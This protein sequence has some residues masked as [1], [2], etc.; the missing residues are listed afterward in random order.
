MP[1]SLVAYGI[2]LLLNRG[3]AFLSVPLLTNS[4]LPPEFG[5]YALLQSM[6]IFVTLASL[7][8]MDESVLRYSNP[9]SAH[10]KSVLSTALIA[11]ISLSLL[12][13]LLLSLFL[14]SIGG[15][16]RLS[17]KGCLLIGTWFLGDAVGIIL[18]TYFRAIRKPVRV[19]FLLVSQGI[20]L[21]A[22]Q[23]FFVISQDGG[24]MGALKSHAITS[25]FTLLFF[26]P[27][28]LQEGIGRPSWH[29]Y[30][31]LLAFGIPTFWICTL[32][33]LTGYFD[34]FLVNHYLGAAATG[35]YSAAYKVGAGT[36][37]LLTAFKMGW[38]PKFYQVSR[39]EKNF[40]I[41]DQ[42]S[43]R[44][45]E[46][47]LLIIGTAALSIVLFIHEIATIPIFH[48]KL[49]GEAYWSSLIF[50]API[51]VAF[52]LDAAITILD[53][54]MYYE[55]RLSYAI[56]AAG[57]AC[58]T[59]LFLNIVLLPRMG[60]MGAALATSA[61]YGVAFTLIAWFNYRIF[62]STA[63]SKTNL[64]ILFYFI[65][66]IMIASHPI[67]LPWRLLFFMIH[68]SYAI[69]L[70]LKAWKAIRSLQ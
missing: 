1:V 35:L 53:S 27:L 43:R 46:G 52:V 16:E 48:G 15:F 31:K 11:V 67:P 62:H 29:Q 30:R 49:I 10:R 25:L 50:V 54:S 21:I 19:S 13:T 8:G 5:F 65:I 28:F 69:H 20:L 14:P 37:L 57:A 26:L 22:L 45:L 23:Y 61:A 58:T 59:N 24:V 32:Y 42:Y 68:T 17:G 3:L 7:H 18:I 60:L 40:E 47:I 56:L 66:T 36:S 4:L 12:L 70:T 6:G 33:T 2:G 55:K 41:R 44:A 63:L 38:Y 64:M 39:S 51:T 9:E 34:R